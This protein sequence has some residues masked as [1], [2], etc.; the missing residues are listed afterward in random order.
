MSKYGWT[1]HDGRTFGIHDLYENSENRYTIRNSWV[2]RLGGEYGGDWSVKT[3]VTPFD[4]NEE[5]KFVSVFF[6]FAKNNPGWIKK[7]SRDKT[8]L[9]GETDDVGKFNVKIDL[10]GN[11]NLYLNTASL[12]APVSVLHENLVTQS[13]F[14]RLKKPPGP[15]NLKEYVGLRGIEDIESSNT[16]VHIFGLFLFYF[17]YFYQQR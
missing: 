3:E 2:K 8:A 15:Q 9:E 11:P 1:A 16:V 6:Y 4:P 7:I 13:Y 10:H 5:P 17:F 12:N 14:I